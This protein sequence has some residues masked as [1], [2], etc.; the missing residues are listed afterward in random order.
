[1]KTSRPFASIAVACEKTPLGWAQSVGPDLLFRHG[2]SPQAALCYTTSAMTVPFQKRFVA[3]AAERSPLCVGIDPSAD[4]LKGW[5]LADDAQGLLVVLRA[6]GRDLRAARRLRQAAGRLFRAARAGG[7]GGAAPH[8]RSGAEPW[9]ARHHRRQAGR[10][11]LDGGGLRRGLL[12][13]AQP[14]WRRR[15]DAE[16]LSR[17]WLAGADRRTRAP[18]GRRGVCRGAVVQSRRNRAAAGEDAGWP[19]GGRAPGRPD[20]RAE[21]RRWR[22]RARSDRRGRRGDA[23]A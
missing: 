15:H 17:P 22:G 19:L 9:R 11:R 23:G 14:V 21:R 10:H 6:H 13:A 1:M 2:C 18:R 12:G 8:R 5:G 4:M 16:R 7:N 20:Y 3:L